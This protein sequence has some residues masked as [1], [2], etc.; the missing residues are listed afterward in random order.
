LG[1]SLF[2]SFL[3]FNRQVGGKDGT[4]SHNTFYTD[5]ATVIL[6][7]PVG[8]TQSDTRAIIDILR[9]EKRL[10]HLGDIFLWYSEATIPD[11]NDNLRPPCII[12]TASYSDYPDT[13]KSLGAVDEHI[14]EGL[15][16]QNRISTNDGHVLVTA[17]HLHFFE[18]RMLHEHFYTGIQHIPYINIR[19]RNAPLPPGKPEQPRNYFLAAF[20]RFSDHFYIRIFLIFNIDHL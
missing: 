9:A 4:L 2:I 14:H 16:E 19:M 20:T 1:S 18:I 7:N 13:L 3:T 12:T 17:I 15:L 10:E 8:K 6:N 5:P 11:G